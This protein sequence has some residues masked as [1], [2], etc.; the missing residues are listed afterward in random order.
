MS[1]CGVL[2]ICFAEKGYGVKTVLLKLGKKRNEHSSRNINV[3]LDARKI[4]QISIR[5]KMEHKLKPN[6]K[7]ITYLPVMI[8][9]VILTMVAC[10]RP[11]C[12]N[13]NPI[14]DKYAINSEEYKTE[15]MSQIEKYGQQNLT[16]WFDSYRVENEKEYIT[17]KIQNDSLCAKGIIQVNDWNKIEGIKRTKGKGYVGAKLKGLTFNVENDSNRIELVYKDI[18]RIVD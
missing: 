5:Y 9:L 7:R 1:F 15:L 17:V 11:N 14:F 8:S 12:E 10:D 6:M 2:K 18:T 13:K 16:Y 3:L 4:D